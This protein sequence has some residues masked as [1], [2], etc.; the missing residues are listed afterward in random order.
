MNDFI[1]LLAMVL[2]FLLSHL[3]IKALVKLKD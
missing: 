3:M 1:M 2:F